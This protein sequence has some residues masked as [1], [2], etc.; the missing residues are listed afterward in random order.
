[1]IIENESRESDEH[2][3]I[4]HWHHQKVGPKHSYAALTDLWIK[5]RRYNR[6]AIFIKGLF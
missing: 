1:M 2:K 6:I 3:M 5:L 4:I